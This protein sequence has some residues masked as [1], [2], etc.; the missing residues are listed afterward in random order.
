MEAAAAV[1]ERFKE[2]VEGLFD[3]HVIEQGEDVADKER[4]KETRRDEENKE[5]IDE[6]G[7]AFI[8]FAPGSLS[9]ATLIDFCGHYKSTTSVDVL[10]LKTFALAFIK[11]DDKEEAAECATALHDK[12]LWASGFVSSSRVFSN[13]LNVSYF[14]RSTNITF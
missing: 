11:F 6:A 1:K 2:E 7:Y 8:G 12:G 13:S 5:R 10:Q 9:R 4:N 3:A 14:D